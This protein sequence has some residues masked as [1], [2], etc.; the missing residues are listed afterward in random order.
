MVTDVAV[1]GQGCS[2]SQASASM[3]TEAIKGHSLEEIKA[4]SGDFI[5]LMTGDGIELDEAKPGQVLGDLEA[6]AGVREFPVR[7][8]CATLG[9]HTMLDALELEEA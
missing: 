8:K 5:E 4:V 6:L 7:I 9:W 3:M 1:S 2:I